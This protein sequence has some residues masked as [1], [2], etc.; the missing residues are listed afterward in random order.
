MSLFTSTRLHPYYARTA[1]A[2]PGGAGTAQLVRLA[3]R[4]AMCTGTNAIH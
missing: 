2:A 3:L 4:L 1:V